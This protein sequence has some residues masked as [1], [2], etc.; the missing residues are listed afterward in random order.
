MPELFPFLVAGGVIGI[1]ALLLL[2]VRRGQPRADEQR[3]TLL[4]RRKLLYRGFA[5]VMAIGVPLGVT[6][7]VFVFPP[8]DEGD[9]YAILGVQALFIGLSWPLLW[10][11]LG[12]VLLVTPEGL[13]CRS[14]WRGS[15]FVPWDDVRAV[16]YSARKSC[17][18]IQAHDGYCFRVPV[19]TAR[20]DHFLQ[21]CEEELHPDLLEAA[22]EGYAR[23]GRALPMFAPPQVDLTTWR[24]RD[25]GASPGSRPRRRDERTH[26]E[27]DR[28]RRD[29]DDY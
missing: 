18:L 7:R 19:I 4:F 27:D 3:G 21:R 13:R 17:F 23:V 29:P 16:S 15:R 11:A 22:W 9:V 1:L 12:F 6:V 25:P 10:D 2:A 28:T 24:D 26:R 20:L 8:Q 14:P 5:L